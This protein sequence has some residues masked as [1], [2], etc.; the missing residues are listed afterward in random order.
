MTLNSC[1]LHKFRSSG[2][3]ICF[4]FSFTLFNK[5][6]SISFCFI[7]RPQFSLFTRK[8]SKFSKMLKTGIIGHIHIYISSKCKISAN[9]YLFSKF[10]KIVTK[11][12]I[13]SVLRCD[14]HEPTFTITASISNLQ[15]QISLNIVP[16]CFTCVIQIYMKNETQE[17]SFLNYLLIL[18]QMV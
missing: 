9:F 14:C 7:S 6:I 2:Y 12:S 4:L 13:A 18:Q 5:N 11:N 8:Q 10:Q 15:N 16:Y 3:T 1:S 17:I